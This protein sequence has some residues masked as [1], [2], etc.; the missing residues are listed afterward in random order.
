M[1]SEFYSRDEIL[2][3]IFSVFLWQGVDPDFV[4]PEAYKILG[5]FFCEKKEY[6]I[7]DVCECLFKA[8]RGP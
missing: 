1:S 6:K 2:P 4:M 7:R 8:L 5:P 3:A